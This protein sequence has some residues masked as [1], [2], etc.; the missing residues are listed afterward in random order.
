MNFKAILKEELSMARNYGMY[1]ETIKLDGYGDPLGLGFSYSFKKRKYIRP[2]E[3][4]GIGDTLTTTENSVEVKSL[5][6]TISKKTFDGGIGQRVFF[7]TFSVYNTSNE[8]WKV[9]Y[10]Y[11]SF[12]E[13]EIIA[14]VE[15]K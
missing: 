7:D 8:N 5:A 4:M 10:K 15:N 11:D 14:L 6:E 3:K 9:Y 13:T 12:V 1:K 2:I